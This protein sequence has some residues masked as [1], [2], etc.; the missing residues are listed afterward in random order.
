[1]QLAHSFISHP[2]KKIHIYCYDILCSY[3]KSVSLN[4]AAVKLVNFILKK[5]PFYFLCLVSFLTVNK[6]NNP[7]LKNN[8]CQKSTLLNFIKSMGYFYIT[9]RVS[10]E[11]SESEKDFF[12]I[13]S[14][15]TDIHSSPLRKKENYRTMMCGRRVS[16]SYF[17]LAHF[18]TVD[19]SICHST[20][21]TLF[22][23]SC[24]PSITFLNAL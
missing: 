23:P 22:I 9:F 20:H 4:S 2:L 3:V 16:V 5:R 24:Q 15:C 12:I 11:Q 21:R 10:R 6:K 19:A 1:M 13:P 17:P 18:C 8:C 14:L 7:K